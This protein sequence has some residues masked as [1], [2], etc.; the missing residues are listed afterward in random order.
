MLCL[1][2]A[3]FNY[4]PP[5]SLSESSGTTTVTTVVDRHLNH[6]PTLES[7]FIEPLDP[8]KF[9]TF[10]YQQLVDAVK[11]VEHKLHDLASI[12]P[13]WFG[14]DGN[15]VGAGKPL[16]KGRRSGRMM[17]GNWQLDDSLVD[18]FEDK[19]DSNAQSDKQV[20]L[21]NSTLQVARYN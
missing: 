19:V 17:F 20:G 10:E 15:D 9:E 18:V 7:C 14:V 12:S 21:T 13:L 16:G 11:D 1:H 5:P 4:S 2:P 6:H 8:G 3:D